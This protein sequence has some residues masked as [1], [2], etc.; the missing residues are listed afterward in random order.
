MAGL[1]VTDIHMMARSYRPTLPFSY[2]EQQGGELGNYRVL[3][4]AM[5]AAF[6]LL[7]TSFLIRRVNI[8]RS[9]TCPALFTGGLEIVIVSRV[10]ILT[11]CCQSRVHPGGRLVREKRP[12]AGAPPRIV[13]YRVGR[14]FEPVKAG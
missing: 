5:C 3:S 9:L 2:G 7:R 13:Q 14:G 4:A 10:T 6:A 1:N 12:T 11:N 8:F